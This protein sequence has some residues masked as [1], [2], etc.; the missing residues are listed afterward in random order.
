MKIR[1]LL[2][3]FILGTGTAF[4][5]DAFYWT[6]GEKIPLWET[7]QIAAFHLKGEFNPA[8][9]ERNLTEE[10]T[11][12][13]IRQAEQVE[14]VVVWYAQPQSEAL[15]V[16]AAKLGIPADNLRSATWAHETA[17]GMPMW[18]THEIMYQPNNSFSQEGLTDYLSAFEDVSLTRSRTGFY[19]LETEKL[20]D[21][22]P[23]ANGLHESGLVKWAQP[24]FGVK[25]ILANDPLFDR[26]YYLENTGLFVFG[27]STAGNDIKVVN[28]WTV[29]TGSSNIKVAVVD[30][31]IEPHEDLVDAMGTTR[32]LTGYDPATGT[33]NVTPQ[34]APN[35]HGMACAGII[36]ATNDNNK[37]VKGIA[38]EVKILP[39]LVLLD[40]A[41]AVADYAD[42]INWSRLNGAD[43]INNSWAFS[44]C[45]PNLY[46]AIVDAVVDSALAQ[47]R[48]GLGSVV[49]FASGTDGLSCI[50]FPGNIP[51]ALTI[52]ATTQTGTLAPYSHS[53]TE[54]DLVG[55]S[56]PA[57]NNS[58]V[59]AIDRT[60]SN[61][62]NDGTGSTGDFSDDKYTKYFGGTSA[63]TAEA[64][65]VAALVLSVDPSLTQQ[66][67]ANILTSTAF[68]MGISGR[69][70]DYGF[71]R[72]H[73][74]NAVNAATLP[75]T[76]L[77]ANGRQV[78]QQI[79]LEWV[80]V[81]E[82]NTREFVVEKFVNQS[83]E[84]IGRVGAAGTSNE[85]RTYRFLDNSAQP[86]NNLYRLTTFDL[87][88]SISNTSLIEVFF[89]DQ[90]G[91]AVSQAMPNPSQDG[92]RFL[93][94]DIN[95]GQIRYQ[96]IDVN[97]KVLIQDAIEVDEQETRLSIGTASL[98][99][100]VYVVQFTSGRG[101]KLNRK[102]ILR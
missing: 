78:D 72:L 79:E 49:T 71:G 86:G 33:S 44:D 63:A 27:G 32:I 17:A 21:V 77:S 73:A 13:A 23:I 52:G 101:Q 94:R 40:G 98:A 55:V 54:L 24:N 5:Q 2:L 99:A 50:Y 6:I 75:I 61:G 90:S 37:G 87:D 64:S 8:L 66:Q 42:A 22:L 97:G 10:V 85:A 14:R 16:L 15:S 30:E 29:T 70:D 76:L 81:L 59:R 43:V 88:G 83:Y 12:L 51:E 20:E 84:Q 62:Y 46:M 35:N 92:F 56:S 53:G 19:M 69:D 102:V 91:F 58:N 3:C 9:L 41:G 31:G 67:V 1:L 57:T 80:S 68:D 96:L 4:G 38:P 74:E 95:A 89:V 25:P 100:G 7:H 82:R 47:G 60:G 26:Q 48:G 93:L 36:A 45:T 39:V 11:H 34:S 18:L 65:G 28:A